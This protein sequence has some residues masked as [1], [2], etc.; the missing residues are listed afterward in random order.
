MSDEP[1]APEPNVDATLWFIPSDCEG[2]H[3]LLGN[4]HTF[5]GRMSAWCP[6]K[7][8]GYCV[9]AS[10]IRDASPEARVWVAGFLAGNEPRPPQDFDDQT[11]FGSAEYAR[12]VEQVESFRL[13]G[14]WNPPTV[15][16]DSLSAEAVRACETLFRF[17]DIFAGRVGH[18]LAGRSVD[19]LLEGL[20]YATLRRAID[21]YALMAFVER[22][23]EC[24]EAW[25][26]YSADKRTPGG[27]YFLSDQ[28]QVGSVEAGGVRTDALTFDSAAEACAT[29]ILRELDYWAALSE[30]GRVRPPASTAEHSLRLDEET[31]RFLFDALYAL[32]EHE[33]AGAPIP[34]NDR[35][36]SEVL[37]RL[38]YALG[39]HLGRHGRLA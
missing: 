35:R 21:R 27:F 32:G 15:N 24:I 36:G 18:P 39:R 33:A 28:C 17:P 31:A 8:T 30:R 20:D 12:W 25:Q 6:T 23:P 7:R 34:K 2:K 37:G 19:D 16:V 10:Q 5:R 9:S 29:Y 26:G 4:P 14:T 3:Y 1:A 13:T 38:L 11:N 22:H